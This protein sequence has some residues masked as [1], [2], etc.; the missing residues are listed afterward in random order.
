ME[1]SKQINKYIYNS[2]LGLTLSF[3][4]KTIKELLFAPYINELLKHSKSGNITK[5]LPKPKLHNKY[6]HAIRTTIRISIGLFFRQYLL[7]I[8]RKVY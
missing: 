4:S 6:F 8:K 1:E 3:P 5:S 2:N 7:F